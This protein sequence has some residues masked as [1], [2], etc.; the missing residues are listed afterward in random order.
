[1][2][3]TGEHVQF[4][5][6]N[7][8]KWEASQSYHHAAVVRFMH[9]AENPNL[10]DAQ[11]AYG[12]ELERA[13]DNPM[14]QD[15][16]GDH[17]RRVLKW[18]SKIHEHTPALDNDK[19]FARWRDA[20]YIAGQHHDKD[21]VLGAQW[22]ESHPDIPI[23]KIKAGHGTAG[24]I[25]LL[26]QIDAYA[27]YT[28]TDPKAAAKLFGGA[29]YIT[30]FHE[31]VKDF[32]RIFASRKP[33]TA[34]DGAP[35]MGAA[36]RAAYDSGDYDMA[37][38]SPAQLL[39]LLREQRMGAN[40]Q[41]FG[42]PETGSHW[43]LDPAF[44]AAYREKLVA[45]EQDVTP[46]LAGIS[47][48]DRRGLRTAT[49]LTVTAD[50]LDMVT[51]AVESFYR[52]LESDHSIHRLF[53][54]DSAEIPLIRDEVNKVLP[55][56]IP[57]LTESSD[58][59]AVLVAAARYGKED[60]KPD[61]D[62][63]RLMWELLHAAQMPEGSKISS[64]PYVQGIL[65]ENVAVTLMYAKRA[66]DR[67]MRG[68]YTDIRAMY[69][70]RERRLAQKVLEKAGFKP[71]EATDFLRSVADTDIANV[72]SAEIATTDGKLAG[73]FRN[74]VDAYEH[75]VDHLTAR[76]Q[77]KKRPGEAAADL[78]P[79]GYTNAQ[80]E[81]FDDYCD[82]MLGVLVGEHGIV[83]DDLERF[84]RSVDE[85]LMAPSIPFKVYEQLGDREKK[86]R[87]TARIRFVL[88][89]MATGHYADWTESV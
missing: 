70:W 13:L 71:A 25:M 79:A 55:D 46:I 75:A 85:G 82:R 35:L 3:G 31:N 86:A 4:I 41:G 43:G 60:M 2:P 30:T 56:D 10:T 15:H 50:L 84:R 18:I 61:S 45:M 16:N 11:R 59:V 74:R 28:K 22:Q 37:T 29:A 67:L 63:R 83:A 72:V 51:P 52:K 66:G 38:I 26:A 40:P 78:T 20:A 88:G 81:A 32:G 47:D 24:A 89:A 23:G 62:A 76:L 39:S 19:E 6:L 12:D 54:P 65:R 8:P 87:E 34:E 53:F 77:R 49:E 69:D 58:P 27:A 57:K 80:L 33:L 1:M 42:R 64:S 21:Q 36:L 44:E 48:A 68:D 14:L 17:D 7:V 73:R 9:G 5:P